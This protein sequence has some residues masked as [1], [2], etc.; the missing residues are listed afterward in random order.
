MALIS[1][2]TDGLVQQYGVDGAFRAI[3]EAG[4]DGADI[5]FDLL[6]SHRDILE[7]KRAPVFDAEGD[8]SLQFFLPYRD[9]AEKWGVKPLQAHAP[10]PSWVQGETAL[11]EY[12]TQAIEKTIAGCGLIGCRLLVVHPLF[13]GYDQALPPEEEWAMNLSFF[14]RLIP[15][16]RKHQVIL[17]LENMFTRYRGKIY[18]ACCS[19]FHT[20]CRYVDELNAMAGETRFGF[21]LDT[22]HALLLGKDMYTVMTAL[23]SRIQCFHIHDNNGVNDLHTAPY[24]GVLDWNRFCQGLKAIGY[25]G[26]LSF[27]THGAVNAI[28]PALIP[29][30]LRFIAGAGRL[31]ARKAG[32]DDDRRNH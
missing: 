18:H 13:A 15:A 7:N 16:A 3:R 20:A 19:D 30:M 14:A 31:F 17:C 8:E 6:L 21:C 27:E 5:N 1:V 25:R 4:F 24:L 11:N 22:G 9:A 29:E 2:Q 32:M 12:L 28:D 26:H 23:G 10:F